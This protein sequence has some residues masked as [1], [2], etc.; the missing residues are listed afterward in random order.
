MQLAA[1]LLISKTLGVVAIAQED[2]PPAAPAPSAP[3]AQEGEL[4]ANAAGSEAL[5]ALLERLLAVKSEPSLV[6][7]TSATPEVPASS[8][9]TRRTATMRRA[10]D[11]VQVVRADGARRDLAYWDQTIELAIGDEVRQ[12]GGRSCALLD[13]GD[14]THGRFDGEAIWRMTAD[15][16]AKPREL[17][18]LQLARF[19]ELW[20]VEGVDMV[21]ALPGGNE[22]AG[23]ATR[24]TLHDH[25][26]RAIEVRVTGPEPVVVRSPYLGDRLTTVAPGQRIFLPVLTE[27]SAIIPHLVREA[28]LFDDSR[29]RLRVQAPEQLTLTARELELEVSG[30]GLIPGI[31]R[32][33]GARV[34]VKPGETL[35]LT[36]APIGFPRRQEQDE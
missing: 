23:T 6:D 3:A 2:P 9:P 32:A 13:Y 1:V 5:N 12:H 29:G 26:R 4:P 31:A 36:R 30:S 33:C 24:I 15:A 35:R 10:A 34:M 20:L 14:G 7:P 21:I 22:I 28:V 25:D 8:A 27:P 11:A 17:E 18:V 19:C 16:I